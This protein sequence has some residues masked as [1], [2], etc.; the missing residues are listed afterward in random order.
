RSGQINISHAKGHFAGYQNS[1]VDNP[2]FRD[3]KRMAQ[4][5]YIANRLFFDATGVGIKN[6]GIGDTGLTKLY[7]VPP[8]FEDAF[9]I[10]RVFYSH[11]VRIYVALIELLAICGLGWYFL[12]TK[13]TLLIKFITMCEQV[14]LLNIDPRHLAICDER[15]SLIVAA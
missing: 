12:Q 1:L 13:T 11:S 8:L 4:P 5:S 15:V 7:W 2:V 3:Q 14:H 6:G 9:S 10:R